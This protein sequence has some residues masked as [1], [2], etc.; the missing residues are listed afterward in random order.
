LNPSALKQVVKAILVKTQ[1]GEAKLDEVRESVNVT[2][3]AFDQTMETMAR[4]GYITLD[5][6]AVKLSTEQRVRLAVRAV[7]LGADFQ[8]VSGSLGWLEFEELAAH[9]FE[10][11]GFTV[12]RR[13]RFQAEGRRWEM[14]VLASRYP[15]IVCAECKHYT[16][17]MGNSTARNIVETHL[18]KTEVFSRHL[19]G[20]AKVDGRRGDPHHSNPEPH[21]DEDIQ[22]DAQRLG[23]GPHKLPSLLRGV[24]GADGPLQGRAARVEAQASADPAPLRRPPTP[25]F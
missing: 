21:Q 16:R 9:V 1:S 6:D 11:N 25:I 17:G 18:E 2:N 22:E 23:A 20:Q 5:G 3:A 19:P 7:E 13:Y 14:D 15:Y 4:E 8:T 10:E 24:P 12:L